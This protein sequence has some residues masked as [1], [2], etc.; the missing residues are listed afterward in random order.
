MIVY[1]LSS[2]LPMGFSYMGL[3]PSGAL[4]LPSA[5]F[6]PQPPI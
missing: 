4:Q 6:Q 2:Y 1:S 3:L 5:P